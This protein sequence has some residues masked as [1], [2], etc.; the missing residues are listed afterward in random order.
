MNLQCPTIDI[1][2]DYV[3]CVKQLQEHFRGAV[4]VDPLEVARAINNFLIDT[5]DLEPELCRRCIFHA[6]GWHV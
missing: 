1:C 6:Y 2:C 5:Q 4:D 3:V